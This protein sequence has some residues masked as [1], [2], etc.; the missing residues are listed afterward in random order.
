MD[1]EYRG[2][3]GMIKTIKIK[4]EMNFRELM[5]Y[6]IQNDVSGCFENDMGYG[7]RVNTATNYFSFNENFVYGYS[8]TY[9]VEVEEE[10]TEDTTLNWLVEITNNSSANCYYSLK[11]EDIVSNTTKKI[12]ALIDGD[13]QLVWERNSDE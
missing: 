11:I 8:E 12:Y 13:L 4:K 10:I 2:G 5:E 3:S 1:I 9:E 6:I 7:F